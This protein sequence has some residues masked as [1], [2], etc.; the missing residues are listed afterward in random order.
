MIRLN[1]ET[2][3]NIKNALSILTAKLVYTENLVQMSKFI[4][5]KHEDEMP[6]DAVNWLY[7]NMELIEDLN[8]F[9]EVGEIANQLTDHMDD[10]V[11]SDT[12]EDDDL[13]F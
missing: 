4:I 7:S 12:T 2:C 8:L 9:G 10:T 5:E 3:T 13:P 6:E 11:V 1:N